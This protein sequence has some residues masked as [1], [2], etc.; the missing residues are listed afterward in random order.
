MYVRT[1]VSCIF[2]HRDHTCGW[3]VG[4][5]LRLELG[6]ARRACVAHVDDD[7]EGAVVEG[8]RLGVLSRGNGGS[9][10]A[11]H[12]QSGE[13]VAHVHVDVVE[14]V[15][16]R[17]VHV[18][19]RRAVVGVHGDDNVPGVDAVRQDV[20]ASSGVHVEGELLGGSVEEAFEVPAPAAG[21]HAVDVVELRRQA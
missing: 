5:V 12:G 21:F 20:L 6:L 1:Y 3:F 14:A 10:D 15:T 8:V 7:V 2:Q 19:A 4:F 9:R 18:V 11:F 17:R 13:V 16:V